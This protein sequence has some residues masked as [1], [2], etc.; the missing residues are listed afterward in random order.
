[1]LLY[2]NVQVTSCVC[3]TIVNC[4][5]DSSFILRL[6]SVKLFPL[7]C[8]IIVGVF[9]L[10]LYK[11]V[12]VLLWLQPSLWGK[13]VNIL[14]FYFT[15]MCNNV[16]LICIECLFFVCYNTL[17]ARHLMWLNTFRENM[18]S[19][20]ISILL[21]KNINDINM[22]IKIHTLISLNIIVFW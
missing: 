2:G 6:P 22:S 13:A 21:N 8:K 1:M 15:F 9:P 17:W 5:M 11:F 12:L 10:S 18:F 3:V 14:W 7:S 19:Y 20:I 16:H 4:L